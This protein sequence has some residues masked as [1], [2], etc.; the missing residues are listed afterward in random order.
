MKN[1]QISKGDDILDLSINLVVG[2]RADMQHQ[3]QP[4]PQQGGNFAPPPQQGYDQGG[5]NQQPAPPVDMSYQQGG[6]FNN[7]AGYP[8]NYQQT[9]Y[10]R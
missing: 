5:F 3:Q 6:G 1:Y 7:N 2:A 10:L 8:Q 9:K 4:S